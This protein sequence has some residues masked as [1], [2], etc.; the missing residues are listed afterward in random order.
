MRIEI[1]VHLRWSD[2]DAYG[3]V[4]NVDMLRLLEIARIE[5]FWASDSQQH[6]T[7]ILDAL[8]GSPT[9]TYVARQEIEY[10]APLTYRREPV[11][12]E[13][14]I[15]HIGGASLDICYA[16]RDPHTTSQPTVYA[17]ASTTLVMVD[18]ASGTPRRIT[19]VEREAW[20]GY[21]GEPVSFR[22]RRSRA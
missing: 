8:P 15:G 12:V 17:Q 5:A 20:V 14:W 11:I 1:P 3:H 7:G 18:T 13:L 6:H 9:A 22:H 19:H 10:L 16:I 4:N 21:V 2:M